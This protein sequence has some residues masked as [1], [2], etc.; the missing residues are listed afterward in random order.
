MKKRI[1]FICGSFNQ[2]TQMHKIAR[3]LPGYEQYF[4]PYYC[5]PPLDWAR[6]L[7]LT[8]F[9]VIGNK[10]IRR[11]T[12]YLNDHGLKMDFQGRT[13]QYDLVVTC[14]DLIVPRNVRG[15][16]IVLVQEGLTDPENLLFQ[17]VKRVRILPR[18]LASTSTNGLSDEYQQFCVASEGYRDLFV[19][20]GVDPGKIAVTGM[21]NFDDCERYRMNSFPHRGFVLV[22]TSD[23]RETFKREN[24]KEFILRAHR[25]AAGRKLIFK[26]HP[27]EN[28]HRATREIERYAPGALV[29]HEGSAEVMIANCDVL[30]TRYSSTVLVGLALGKEVHSDIAREELRR[31]LP[32]QNSSAAR[33]IAEVCRGIL[34]PAPVEDESESRPRTPHRFRERAIPRLVLAAMSRST[35]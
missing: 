16:P 5:D 4:T 28:V 14:S 21:P 29:F 1:L 26:L 25:I 12:E 10:A 20:K 18:W 33:N 3:E 35:S 23:F 27:N 22:C 19:A 15:K 2:T 24:R 17:L 32:L 30:I 11:V 34:E 13:H 31:L 6:R 9:A 8:E 7:G